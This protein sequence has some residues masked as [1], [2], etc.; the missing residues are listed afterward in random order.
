MLSTSI[1]TRLLPKSI[2][3]YILA[4]EFDEFSKTLPCTILYYLKITVIADYCET[5]KGHIVH[6]WVMVGWPR[7]ILN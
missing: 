4:F 3:E 2:H 5:G 6:S 7:G 1:T